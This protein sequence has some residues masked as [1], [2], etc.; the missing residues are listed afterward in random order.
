MGHEPEGNRN[1]REIDNWWD[2]SAG[3][4]AGHKFRAE[5]RTEGRGGF[6]VGCRRDFRADS[7]TFSRGGFRPECRLAAVPLR[8]RSRATGHP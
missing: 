7:Q 1:L 4:K 8:V 2:A 3:G 6:R 5:C